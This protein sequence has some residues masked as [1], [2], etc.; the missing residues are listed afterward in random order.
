M[1]EFRVVADFEPRGDQPKAIK[2]LARGINEGMRAQTLMG[3]TGSGKTF[4]ISK[5]IEAVQKPTL[6]IAHIKTLAAQL[7]RAATLWRGVRYHK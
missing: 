6:V 2:Q 1:G 7:Y 4:T 3:I 5:V